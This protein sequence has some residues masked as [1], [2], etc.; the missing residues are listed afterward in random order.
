MNFLLIFFLVLFMPKI[1]FVDMIANDPVKDF[2]KS[3]KIHFIIVGVILGIAIFLVLVCQIA[4]ILFRKSN[5]EDSFAVAEN[6]QRKIYPVLFWLSNIIV[7][8]VI[9]KVMHDFNILILL[10]II[11]YIVAII[12]RF[13]K[14]KKASEMVF[15]IG[16]IVLAIIVLSS[17]VINYTT[18]DL[19]HRL[20]D[21]APG[22]QVTEINSYIF[23]IQKI[24]KGFSKVKVIYKGKTYYS[25]EELQELGKIISYEESNQIP[26]TQ[27]SYYM[28]KYKLKGEKIKEIELDKVL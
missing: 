27:K 18:F 23:E 17:M 24:N 28:V 3:A 2:I 19:N 26:R 7:F 12:L 25:V 8:F 1:V 11:I 16:T 9:I 6:F 4:K 5:D 13:Q 21:L 10:F 20:E 15:G 14:K 22:N